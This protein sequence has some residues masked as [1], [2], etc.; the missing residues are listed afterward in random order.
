MQIGNTQA[1]EAERLIQKLS[2]NVL[3]CR[4]MPLGP[5]WHLDLCSPF[6]RFY[7]NNRSGAWLAHRGVRYPMGGGTFW[8]VPAWV[9][10]QTGVSGSVRQDYMHFTVRGLPAR[11]F[12]NL[13]SRPLRLPSA[14]PLAALCHQWRRNWKSP[15]DLAR[16]CWAAAVAQTAFAAA[17]PDHLPA[18]TGHSEPV[19]A[20][21]ECLSRRMN[22]PP[23]N[24]ELARI[25][26]ASEDHFVRRFREETGW[27]PARFGRERRLAAAAE[28]LAVTERTMEDIAEAAGF[29][30]RFHFSRVFKTRFDQTPAAYRRMHRRENA[31]LA[32]H[33]INMAS[34]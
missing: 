25:F 12:Q 8:M 21:M 2:I 6:W 9:R 3:E 23:T 4:R 5:E 19:Q 18:A 31:A 32:D 28:W 10:F 34:P 7:V 26:G 27:T 29:T 30:D 14:T 16:L 20:V 11:L 22:P 17:L 33:T 24:N 15:P 13:F 1:T